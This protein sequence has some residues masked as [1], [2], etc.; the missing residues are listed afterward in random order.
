[1][2]A[3]NTTLNNL[4]NT[5]RQIYMAD[6]Y[7]V[8]TVA[9]AIYRYTSADTGLTVGGNVFLSSLKI[10]RGR[11]RRAVGL[12][13]DTLDITVY[14][15]ASD[16]IGG[17]P[18]LTALRTGALDG[19]TLLLERAYMATWG[20]TSPGT[21]IQ[22]I[23]RVSES[24]FG[25]T[26]AKIKIKSDLELL[27]IQMPHNLYQPGCV[28]SLYDSGCGLVKA[29]YGAASAVLAGSTASMLLC[30]LTQAAAYF[31]QG[32]ITCNSGANSGVT[33]TV[34]SYTPGVVNLS[35]PLPIAPSVSD[36]FTAYPGCDKTQ[37]TCTGKFNNVV[38]FRG[39]PYVPV[40]ETAL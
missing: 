39:F 25:R 2:K 19:A 29:S 12:E 11:I 34:K 22:F 38:N 31:D 33:R 17:T 20:D 18:F 9:G 7:T 27:N 3:G 15:A 6:L 30:G 24:R 35:Y 28:H 40:P 10:K 36:A 13:V 37:A 16:L 32:T 21:L 23:G 26:E 14:P 4:L 8:T 1:M 5:S